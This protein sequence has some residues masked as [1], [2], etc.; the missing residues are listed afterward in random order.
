[1]DYL[2][3]HVSLMETKGV[4]PHKEQYSKNAIYITGTAKVITIYLLKK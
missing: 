2:A 3:V 4:K 1:M